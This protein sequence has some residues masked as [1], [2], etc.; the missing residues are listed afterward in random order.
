[1]KKLINEN[2]AGGKEIIIGLL[3]II[4]VFAFG[5]QSI[6]NNTSDD[7]YKKLRV[8]ADK[9]VDAV[10]IH[11]DKYTNESGIYYLYELEDYNTENEIIIADPSNKSISCNL[12]E[13][14]VTI[15]NPKKVTLRCGDYLIE[16]EYQKKYYVYE[17]GEWQQTDK[18]GDTAFLYKYIKDGKAAIDKYVTEYEFIKTYNEKE[19]TS[20]ETADEAVADAKGKGITVD[21]DMFYRTKTLVKEIG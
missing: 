9:F 5:L 10:T 19:E 2:G 14:Y 3:V 4:G 1:M 12:Y 21:Y 11:K 8:Q 7:K 6:L 17:I 13:S 16:G 15:D 20:F 18:T